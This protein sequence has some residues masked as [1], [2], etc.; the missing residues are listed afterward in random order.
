VYEPPMCC[1]TGICG[2]TIEPVLPRFA[3]D[4]VWLREQGIKV[5]RYNLAQQPEAFAQNELVKKFL[6]EEGDACLPLILADGKVL[7]RGQYPSREVMLAAFSVAKGTDTDSLYSES[8]EELVAIGASIASNCEP[9]LRYHFSQASRLGISVEDIARAVATARAV[10]AMSAG[11]VISL[12]ERLTN[13]SPEREL[14]G[15]CG[16]KKDGQPCC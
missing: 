8:I 10:K 4:L 12:A 1:A 5:E 3:A 16:P 15:C 2:P 9:C 13:R 7:S 14:V 6:E 11:R